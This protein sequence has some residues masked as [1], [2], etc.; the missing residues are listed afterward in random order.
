MHRAA[1]FGHTDDI[2]ALVNLNTPIDL[3]TYKTCWTPIFCAAQYGNMATF[4]EL[5]KYHPDLLAMRDIRHWALLHVAVNAKRLEIMELLISLGA[6]PHAQT[7]STEF[8]VPEDIKSFSV[9]AGDI[10]RLR[11]LLVLSAYINA[12]RVSGQEVDAVKDEIDDVE[13]LF[14]PALDEIDLAVHN[15]E[16][17]QI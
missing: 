8:F 10:A 2:K 3:R 1:V 9:T 6:D 5:R 7:F 17:V 16:S 11:G 4:N 14:W 12:L 13:D 15:S